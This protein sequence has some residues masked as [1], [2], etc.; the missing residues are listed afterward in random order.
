MS[1]NE[2]LILGKIEMLDELDKKLTEFVEEVSST[3]NVE[4]VIALNKLIGSFHVQR[5]FLV[6]QLEN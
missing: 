6:D 2:T 3:L 5:Q 1:N 4:H